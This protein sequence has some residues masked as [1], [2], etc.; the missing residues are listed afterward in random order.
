MRDFL[1]R[2]L[3]LILSG[4][5]LLFL[6]LYWIFKSADEVIGLYIV[7]YYLGFP[8]AVTLFTVWACLNCKGRRKYF[9]PLSVLILDILWVFVFGDGFPNINDALSFM[10]DMLVTV[11]APVIA[12][13]ACLVIA[14]IRNHQSGV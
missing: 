7:T 10:E 9:A 4:F 12:A 11:T 5:I 13:V 2:R 8:L 6:I 3:L 1:K 14:K